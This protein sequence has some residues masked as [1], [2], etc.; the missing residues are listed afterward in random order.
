MWIF[1]LLWDPLTEFAWSH[2]HIECVLLIGLGIL[3]KPQSYLS[4]VHYIGREITL[5]LIKQQNQNLLSA[6]WCSNCKFDLKVVK[7]G[8][9]HSSIYKIYTGVQNSCDYQTGERQ[10][11]VVVV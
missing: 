5:W 2:D 10:A 11:M 4:L 7:S 9:H 8:V 6:I 3:I 1:F